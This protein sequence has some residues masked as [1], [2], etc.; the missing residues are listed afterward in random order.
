MGKN[1]RKRLAERLRIVVD[2]QPVSAGNDG[3][4]RPVGESCLQCGRH[5]GEKEVRVLPPRYVQERDPYVSS[6]MVRRRFVCLGCYNR[7][8]PAAGMNAAG[9]V[10]AAVC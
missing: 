1:K 4:E 2:V 6:G 10:R 5:I 8:G 7:L 9:E 3:A